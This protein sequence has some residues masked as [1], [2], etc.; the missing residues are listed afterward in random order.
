MCDVLSRHTFLGTIWCRFKARLD[1][2]CS[3][4]HHNPTMP[5]SK[6]D[7]GLSR[8]PHGIKQQHQGGYLGGKVNFGQS[9]NYGLVSKESCDNFCLKNRKPAS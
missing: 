1:E 6:A 7:A 9:D 5:H 2:S 3:N 8:C 4:F